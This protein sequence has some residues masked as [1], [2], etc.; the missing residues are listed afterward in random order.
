MSNFDKLDLSLEKNNKLNT[1]HIT[2][3]AHEIL[4]Q[5]IEDTSNNYS[6]SLKAK[7]LQQIMNCSQTQ[8]YDAL[9]NNDIPGAKKI[10]G[11]GWRVPRDVFL[12]WWYASE[13]S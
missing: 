8:V 12:T 5:R 11:L 7:D 13:L 10:K 6:E 3:T 4:K 1:E 2:V 9:N